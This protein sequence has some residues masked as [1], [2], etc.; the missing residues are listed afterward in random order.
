MYLKKGRRDGAVK[1]ALAG[2]RVK[3][4]LVDEDSC[5]LSFQIVREIGI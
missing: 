3:D 1:S 4:N 2:L 5:D